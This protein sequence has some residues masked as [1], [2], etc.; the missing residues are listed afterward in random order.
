MREYFTPA[1]DD[2]P[3]TGN[4][5][6]SV[7]RR[8]VEEPDRVVCHRRVSR[9]WQPVTA[10]RL[11]SDVVTWAQAMQEA[12]VQR[13]DRVGI[14]GRTSYEWTVVDLA[15]WCLGAVSVPLYDTSSPVQVEG[16]L[17]DSG[18]RAVLVQAERH[19]DA[20]V[21]GRS[22][23]PDLE[24]VWG[25]DLM[26][27]IAGADRLDVSSVDAESIEAARVAVG[28]ADLA[29]LVYTSGSTGEPH[30]CRL[31]HGNLLFESAAV[32][33]VLREAVEGDDAS[34]LL[35]L[36]LAHVLARVLQV[37]A[38]REGIRLGYVPDMSRLLDDV[39]DFGPTVLLGVP[40]VFETLFT[41][42]SQRAAAEGRG[43]RNEAAT[44][45]AIAYSTALD[46]GGVGVLTRSRHRL[47]ERLVY[48]D[49]RRALGGRVE[50]ALSGGA[51]LG[52]RLGH[53]FRGAG[54]PVLEGYG[55]TETTG[56]TTLTTPDDVKVGK[57][58]RPLPG[59]GMRVSDQGELL[60]KGPH[61]FE[62]YWEAPD[63]TAEMIDPS[64]WLRTGDL[65]EIDGDG[66]VR[67]TG[68]TRELI[69]TAGGKNVVP[70]PL[71]EAIRS[72]PLVD[73]CLVVGE[74]QPYVAALVTLDPQTA[75]SWA[76]SQGKDP[77]LRR[78]AE[79]HDVRSAVQEAVDRA[80]ASVSQ[81]E[82]VRAFRVLPETW[83]DQSGELTPSLKLRRAAVTRR[84][85]RE[86]ADLYRR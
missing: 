42:Y 26:Q 85:R 20:V 70:G 33:H 57:V 53:F 13:G 12:G 63:A 52:D 69:V 9:T 16:I 22:R 46:N 25:F 43:R 3:L 15:V 65:G 78:L 50:F 23:C 67:V 1:L 58:G 28:P 5:T 51:P 80:N 73:Q 47:Y 44:E 54:I 24:H 19:A 77:D 83:S 30:G 75:R 62:G 45:A 18:A 17:R 71:E 61:V 82:A 74:D 10:A 79:D 72:H 59:T 29:T 36:P 34:A 68:R 37:T 41:Q 27:R 32:G 31:T 48:A 8:G 39:H 81:A 86:I 84:Y 76:E 64:G 14:L 7:F 40:R 6:D 2:L 66:F 49:L 55:L 56:A 4:L 38:L 21:Q 11:R 60:V 35:V